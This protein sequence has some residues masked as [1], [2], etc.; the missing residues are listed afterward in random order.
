MILFVVE[1]MHECCIEYL[2]KILSLVCPQF[3]VSLQ[4][5]ICN[6]YLQTTW[7]SKI[8]RCM[9]IYSQAIV[10]RNVIVDDGSHVHAVKCFLLCQRSF[11][12]LRCSWCITQILQWIIGIILWYISRLRSSSL[13]GYSC[14]PS[15]PSSC[16][17]SFHIQSLLS[18]HMSANI[19]FCKEALDGW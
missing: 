3:V 6:R 10:Y 11:K 18:L 19:L 2:R 1:P 5:G 8:I 16:N 14:P 9:Q 17:E 7:K 4:L 13:S 15:S 12:L